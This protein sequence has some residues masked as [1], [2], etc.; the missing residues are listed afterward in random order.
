[1]H[2]TAIIAATVAGLAGL[3][4]VAGRLGLA[5]FWPGMVPTAPSTALCVALLAATSIGAVRGWVD[6]WRRG[7]GLTVVGLV[8]AFGV[9]VVVESLP[10]V[11]LDVEGLLLPELG[12]LGGVPLG[13]MS[14]ATGIGL[15]LVGLSL[16]A[17]LARVADGVVA[18][19]SQ[20][21]AICGVAAVAWSTVFVI[22][23]ALGSPLLY[24]GSVVPMALPTSI[25]LVC[26]GLAA[27]FVAG[28]DAVRPVFGAEGSLQSRLVRR[29][30]P[31]LVLFMV[32]ELAWLPL[33]SRVRGIGVP[34][35][36]GVLFAA[37]ALAALTLTASVARSVGSRVEAAE[38]A[39]R[40]S[41]RRYRTLFEN[42]A[43]A[44][45]VVDLADGTLVDVN[46]LA[47]RLTGRSRSELIGGSVDEVVALSPVADANPG[48]A[49]EGRQVSLDGEIVVR[50]GGRLPVEISAVAVDAADGRRLQI[51]F[52]R[53]VSRRRELETRL[54]QSEKME[55]VAQLA[56]GVAHDFNNQLTTISGLAEVLAS[57]GDDGELQRSAERIVQAA[58]R[59][60]DLTRQLLAFARR[61]DYRRETV[62]VDALIGEVIE[63]LRGGVGTGISL[64]HHRAAAP[65]AVS[66][67]PQQLRAAL[68]GLVRNGCEAIPDGG[69]LTV[70]VAATDVTASPEGVQPRL[71]AGRYVTIAVADSGTGMAP[72]V[73]EHLFEPFF[74]TK[75]VGG[76]SGM[77]LAALYGIVSQAGG[78]VR[79]TSRLGHG[80]E[81]TVYLPLVEAAAEGVEVARTAA[82][83][84]GTGRHGILVVDDDDMVR[85]SVVEMV[86]LLGYAVE[87]CDGGRS[88]LALLARPETVVDLV[89][90]DLTMP[91]MNG[92]EVFRHLRELDPTMRVLLSSGHSL[93]REAQELL[94][95]ERVGLLQK[96]YRIADLRAAVEG[97]LGI[98]SG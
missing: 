20:L 58:Q 51:G 98:E 53:D 83:I 78:G 57:R 71:A 62:V 4:W 73:L 64:V 68:S 22:G 40:R 19:L 41:E 2:L 26:L 29:F 11:V 81:V 32:I 46:P 86:E 8:T 79:V 27:T 54:R 30:L 91:D 37:S 50:G 52:Y 48:M 88:A 72:G 10:A 47:E 23:Y 17:S 13:R 97:L 94:S 59:A 87:A 28:R 92:R 6:G 5:A 21:A 9:L 38:A 24:G 80:S 56:G 35:T 90:L 16:A 61:G 93:E 84:P 39:V 67:D 85:E 45:L 74:T 43:D 42:A 95:G 82:A 55:A 44:I 77:G 1:M 25:S 7:A 31:L 65:L 34:V 96:P 63:E 75:P 89:I 66:G 60:G 14:P 49:A 33:A 18:R 69:E 36:I 76:G 12:R 15:V 70:T 3:G